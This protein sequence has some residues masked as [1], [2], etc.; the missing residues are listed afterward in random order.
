MRW[1][2]R[3]SEACQGEGSSHSYSY[4]LG[5][6]KAYPETTGYLIPT[7]LDWAEV[8]RDERCQQLAVR[9]GQWLMRLQRPEGSWAGGVVGGQRPSVFNTAMIVDGL[10][11]LATRRSDLGAAAESARLGVEWLLGALDAEGRWQRGLYVE[12]FLSAYYAYAVA[13]VLRTTLRLGLCEANTPLRCA[14]RHYASYLNSEGYPT[15]SGLKPGLWAFTH[16]L[17]YA[18]QGLWEL[19]IHYQDTDLQQRIALGCQRLAADITKH[20]HIAGRYRR[21]WIGDHSFTCPVANA[22]L[23]ILF[24][25]VGNHTRETALSRWADFALKEAM[26]YQNKG[27]CSNTYGAIPGSVPI[28]GPYMRWRYPNWG[29]KFLLDALYAKGIEGKKTN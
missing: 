1:I 20:R 26:I 21:D 6:A 3:S 18:L 25:I 12:G 13:A 14:L 19:A 11:T 5:W 15:N 28:W 22:Q 2:F 8:R 29:A 10:S 16:T 17:A 4:F 24:R 9:F 27:T 7:L 23:S